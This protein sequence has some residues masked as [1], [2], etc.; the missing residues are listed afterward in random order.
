VVTNSGEK[1]KGVQKVVV[2]AIEA[3]DGVAS[4]V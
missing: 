4:E 1:V 2:A 3:D